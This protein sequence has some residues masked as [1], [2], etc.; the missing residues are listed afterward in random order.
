MVYGIRLLI[1]GVGVGVLAGT[2]LSILNS[3]GQ[4]SAK[5]SSNE[6]VN[7][8]GS[9]SVSQ[10]LGIEAL[11]L[12]L[13]LNQELNPLKQEVLDLVKAEPELKP[14]ILMVDLDTG[15]YVD[16]DSQSVISAASTIK[17]PI[18]GRLFSSG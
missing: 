11:P 17:L 14:R 1:L 16:I 2:G 10:P 7:A 15:S 4:P 6:E 9:G 3:L 12:S 18:F 13:Q 5:A 8:S